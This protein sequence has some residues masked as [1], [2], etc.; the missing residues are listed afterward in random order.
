MARKPRKRLD[1]ALT[2]LGLADSIGKAAGLIMAREV[3]VNGQI[4]DQAGSAVQPADEIALVN[5]MP[6]VSRGGYKLSG[7]FDAFGVDPAGRVCADVGVCTGG[8]TDVLLQSGA[9]KVFAIDVGYGQ[10]DWKLRQ[11][12]RVHVMERTNARYVESLEQPVSLVVIDVSFIS[13]RT[14]LK[15][16]QKW[17]DRDYRP[18]AEVVALIKPQFEASRSQIE[19]G[20]VI[21][22]DDV[23]QEIVVSVVE[24]MQANGWAVCGLVKSSIQGADGNI[25]FLVH[26]KSNEAGAD[27]A[28]LDE[29]AG[30]TAEAWYRGTSGQN[31]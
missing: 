17:M 8:F 12:D 10:L 14:I 29:S 9:S 28:L 19:K 27:L 4:V 31:G 26:L 13:L 30:Q 25:E 3:T 22:D 15:A 11:D 24:W 18:A 16:V 1:V 6:W 2:E 21:K 7:A 23:R 5:V 20:G